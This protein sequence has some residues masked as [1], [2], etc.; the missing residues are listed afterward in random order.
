[1]RPDLNSRTVSVELH[2][3]AQVGH[4]LLAPTVAGQVE[5]PKVKGFV[6]LKETFA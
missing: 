5:Q 2:D 3:L 4:H 6:E 1:M